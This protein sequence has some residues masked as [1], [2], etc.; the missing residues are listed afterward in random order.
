MKHVKLINQSLIS[1]L[2]WTVNP[3]DA[4]NKRHSHSN[5]WDTCQQVTS[6]CY[7][8]SIHLLH[9]SA[10][11][12]TRHISAFKALGKV[13]GRISGRIMCMWRIHP[14]LKRIEKASFFFVHMTS[15]C[16]FR[17]HHYATISHCYRGTSAEKST[18]YRGCWKTHD[19]PSRPHALWM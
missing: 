19:C 8:N 2:G 5:P 12:K 7:C 3:C 18:T 6:M 15:L 11:L 9:Q 4:R 10:E 1:R 16:W 14:W 17:W 13:P